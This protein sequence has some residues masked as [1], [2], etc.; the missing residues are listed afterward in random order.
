[1]LPWYLLI[2]IL[3]VSQYDNDSGAWELTLYND[4]LMS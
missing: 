1:M 2:P 4:N 3:L